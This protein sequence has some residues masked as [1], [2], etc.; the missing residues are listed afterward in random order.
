M[1]LIV[2][3]TLAELRSLVDQV[4]RHTCS[5]S[6]DE[7]RQGIN[8]GYGKALRAI[9]SVNGHYFSSYQDNFTFAANESEHDIS[10]IDPPLWRVTKL[11]IPKI[12]ANS[13]TSERVVWFRYRDQRSVDYE[14]GEASSRGASS[15]VVYDVLTGRLPQRNVAAPTAAGNAAIT[16]IPDL[17]SVVVADPVSG[18]VSV[19]QAIRIPGAG[20]PHQLDAYGSEVDYSLPTDYFGTVVNAVTASG[21]VTIT[22]SPRMGATP[23]VGAFI[24][25]Y[26]SRVLTIAPTFASSQTGRLYYVYRPAK[27]EK[28]TDRLDDIA[29]E[30][31]DMIVAYAASWLLRTTNDAQSERWFLEGQEQRSE[32][33]QDIDPVAEGDSQALE[34]GLPG[35]DW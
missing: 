24:D 25:L 31:R 8:Y 6:R 7:A 15:T 5:Y 14:H 32:C 16:S 22:V 10:S 4:T 30:H 34:T 20:Q 13:T 27:L 29:S 35:G 19:G 12:P 23:T 11:V 17:D 3:I 28:D 21:F 26:R 18:G 33:M 1:G 2:P 9:R